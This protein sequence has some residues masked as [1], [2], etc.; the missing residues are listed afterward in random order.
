MIPYLLTLAC[1]SVLG[2]TCSLACI[3]SVA[4][5]QSNS[6]TPNILSALYLRLSG[7]TAD[8][9]RR[10]VVTFSVDFACT[11][12]ILHISL[13][14]SD[15]VFEFHSD[16]MNVRGCMN[17]SGFSGRSGTTPSVTFFPCFS[18]CIISANSLVGDQLHDAPLF[19]YSYSLNIGCLGP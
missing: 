10:C 14:Y 6:L 4:I 19:V 8:R 12:L 7:I 3:V 9:L 18:L 13:K 17:Y 16:D 11:T 15:V 5:I 2:P 1:N